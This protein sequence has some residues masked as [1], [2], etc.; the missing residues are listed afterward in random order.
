MNKN[1][2]EICSITEKLSVINPSSDKRINWK[3]RTVVFLCLLGAF[4]GAYFLYL[5]LN[6]IGMRGTGKPL[7]TVERRDSTV[8][9][10]A[11]K[12]YVWT[13]VQ[14]NESLFLKDSI[15]TGRGS[16]ASVRLNNGNI[17]DVGEDSLVV[18]DDTT[19]LSLNFLRGSAVVHKADGDA[20]ITVGKDGKSTVEELSAKL[21]N[22]GPLAR[23]F[24]SDK[25]K[26]I[27]FGW[28]LRSKAPADSI[29][30]Q[31]STD[32][33][34]AP[35]VTQN[36]TTTDSKVRELKHNLGPGKYYWR[37]LSKDKVLTE[38]RQLQVMRV[39]PLQPIFPA[40]MQKISSNSTDGSLQFRWLN[41]RSLGLEEVD[42]TQGDHRVEV[43]YDRDF[44]SIVRT[45]VLNPTT[46]MANIQNLP[47]GTVHWRIKS[48]YEGFTNISPVKTFEFKRVKSEFSPITATATHAP[49]PAVEEIVEPSPVPAP[50]PSPKPTP[51]PSPSPKPSPSPSPSPRPLPSPPHPTLPFP[52]E[53]K[54]AAEIVY[55]PLAQK[56]P[57]EASWSEVRHAEGYEVSVYQEVKNSFQRKLV[58]HS[59]TKNTQAIFKG[60]GP[61]EYFWTVRT[62][63]K[64]NIHSPAM[65]LRHFSIN[66]G[67][68]L[69]AP[70]IL[71]PEV[72]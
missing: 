12:S 53:A 61:G 20:K 17:L 9:R 47:D 30:V 64:N 69:A 49:E 25:Q 71:S 58:W 56:K 65:P 41:P 13:N 39:A 5:D 59:K 67:D 21:L 24:I 36:L 62:L 32:K 27:F 35:Q 68:L 7:G 31:V 37:V 66:Y 51:T 16:A 48:T 26:E 2:K 50:S 44:K 19:N 18:M 33:R 1:L 4:L 46:G 29:T 8:R 45:E 57:L 55:N 28:E 38:T 42:V 15:Q 22:P 10:K 34:F 23:Y 11:G 63:G 40:N 3:T 14:P 54:P 52:A 72:Q 70:Q 6:E 43:A 60:L